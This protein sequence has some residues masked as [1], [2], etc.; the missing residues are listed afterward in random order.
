MERFCLSVPAFY[1][2]SAKGKFFALLASF[3][4][5]IEIVFD[6]VGFEGD[7]FAVCRFLGMKLRCPCSSAG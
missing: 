7:D 4:E 3:K 1:F 2:F 6:A 5:S